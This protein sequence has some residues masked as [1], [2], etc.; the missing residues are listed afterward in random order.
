MAKPDGTVAHA[1]FD[2]G[3]SIVMVGDETP[4]GV[5]PSPT[6]LWGSSVL[7]FC[8]LKMSHHG[9]GNGTQ[10]DGTFPSDQ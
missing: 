4:D 8:T 10:S 3:G 6:T 7:S 5:D 2:I 1:E 9:H